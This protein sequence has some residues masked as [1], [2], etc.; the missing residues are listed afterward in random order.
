MSTTPL[1]VYSSGGNFDGELNVADDFNSDVAHP[2]PLKGLI[3]NKNPISCTSSTMATLCITS[4]GEVRTFGANYIYGTLGNGSQPDSYIDSAISFPGSTGLVKY[5]SGGNWHFVCTFENGEVF[6]W[7]RNSEGQLGDGTTTNRDTPIKISLSNIDYCEAGG[8]HTLC[9]TQTG[10]VYSFGLNTYGQLGLGNTTNTNSPTLVTSTSN[11]FLPN[12]INSIAAGGAHSVFILNNGKVYT[13]GQ[14]NFGRLGNGA[15]S[16]GNVSTPVY[17]SGF[18]SSTKCYGG[19]AYIDDISSLSSHTGG[20][21]TLCIAYDGSVKATGYNGYGQLG[22]GT[23]TNRTTPVSTLFGKANNCSLGTYHTLCVMDDG[24][25][26]GSGFSDDGEIPLG[27]TQNQ[28]LEPMNT[29]F[30]DNV[31]SCHSGGYTSSCLKLGSCSN[32]AVGTFGG[33]YFVC[34]NGK[35]KSLN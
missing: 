35:W 19:K 8:F 26:K 28:I 29:L 13:V 34:N 15:S 20:A 10:Q 33:K 9:L 32:S 30:G 17:V 22:D 16:A 7:G 14:Q 6:T 24:R 5:C 11:S 25:V 12:S 23:S 21:Y 18:G 31:L 1:E 27:Y 3:S 2:T 4:N